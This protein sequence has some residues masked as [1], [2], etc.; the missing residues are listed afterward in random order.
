[1]PRFIASLGTKRTMIGLFQNINM[2]NN[3]ITGEDLYIMVNSVHRPS[4]RKERQRRHAPS[5]QALPN[6]MAFIDK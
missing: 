1:M 5:M 4:R 3:S 2:M 6:L